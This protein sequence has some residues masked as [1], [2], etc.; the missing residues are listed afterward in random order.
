MKKLIKNY[1][2]IPTENSIQFYDYDVIQLNN[3]LL[4][5]NVTENDVLYNFSDKFLGGNV[6]NN[7][8]ILNKDC[9]PYDANDALQIFYDD[10]DIH[11]TLSKQI[12]IIN[13]LDI[14]QKQQVQLNNLTETL[15]DLI[16]RLDFLSAV[17]GNAADLR[18]TLTASAF[19]SVGTVTTV[20]TLTN[21]TNIGGSNAATQIKDLDNMIFIASNLNNIN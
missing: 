4:I 2:F 5:T 17:R 9:S 14:M 3:V 16:N 20:G 15:Y 18:V 11:S 10:D 13:F 21:Q 12:D 6:Q 19:T 8:L 7:K 1:E